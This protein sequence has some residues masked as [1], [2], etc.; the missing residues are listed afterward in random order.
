VLG[1][2]RDH[3]PPGRGQL[4]LIAGHV[5][6]EQGIAVLKS[7]R[8]LGPTAGCIAAGDGDD[9]S[10]IAG[11]PAPV[12]AQCFFCSKSQRSFDSRH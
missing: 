1:H 9:R 7:L 10:A 11:F 2:V 5:E 12:K 4:I 3:V 8:P 6:A